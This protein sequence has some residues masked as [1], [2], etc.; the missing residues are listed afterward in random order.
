VAQLEKELLSEAL[1]NA[2]GNQSRAARLLGISERMVRYKT[3]KYR[4]ESRKAAP[5]KTS[6]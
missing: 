3:R 5:P 1:A 2:D 4:L 6:R